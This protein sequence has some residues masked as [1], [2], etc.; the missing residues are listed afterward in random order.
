[1][2]DGLTFSKHC[3][4]LQLHVLSHYMLKM[5]TIEQIDTMFLAWEI[6]ARIVFPLYD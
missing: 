1:M 3:A 5:F 2:P 4:N 6:L